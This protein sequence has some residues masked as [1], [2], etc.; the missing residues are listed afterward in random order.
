MMFLEIIIYILVYLLL[1][2]ILAFFHELAHAF[3]AS[4]FSKENVYLTL[5]D[6]YKNVNFHIGKL[7]FCFKGYKSIV[8]R[9]VGYVKFSIEDGYKAIL[10]HLA[11]PIM[12]LII[13]V[14]LYIFLKYNGQDMV[15]ILQITLNALLNYSLCSFLSTIIPMKKYPFEQ[16]A[17][18][19]SD[20]YKIVLQL[21]KILYK[22]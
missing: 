9:I 15:L 11:G 4:I 8:G 13:T 19:S 10:I 22:G 1:F 12:S 3:V 5:G 6:G 14:C 17:N 2:P 18:T 21:K 7:N 20:G 16:Y